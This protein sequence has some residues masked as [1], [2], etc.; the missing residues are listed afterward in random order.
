[1][2]PVFLQS[3]FAGAF[4]SWMRFLQLSVVQ[5]CAASWGPCCLGGSG[6]IPLVQ[7]GAVLALCLQVCSPLCTSSS[8]TFICF[9][10]S[11]GR[12]LQYILCSGICWSPR[13]G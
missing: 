4:R 13:F 2:K 8:L 10:I 12:V 9:G 1:M 11:F 5:G 6:P 7:T 3:T